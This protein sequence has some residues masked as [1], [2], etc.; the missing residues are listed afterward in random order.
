MCERAHALKLSTK[1]HKCFLNWD[2]AATGMEADGI[3][4]G[5]SRSIELHGLKFNRL[6][7]IILSILNIIKILMT[8]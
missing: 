8:Q 3:S 5:F 1:D 6:I 7:G 4:E 2:K